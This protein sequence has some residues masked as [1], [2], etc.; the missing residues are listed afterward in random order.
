MPLSSLC[1]RLSDRAACLLLAISAF[2][3]VVVGIAIGEAQRL[4]PCPLCIFQRVLYLAIGGGALLA[5]AGR[6]LRPWGLFIA[7]VAALGGIAAA[8]YQ[9]WLQWMADP[10]LECGFGPPNLI[11]Q[12]VEW[13]G[14]QW[15]RLFLATGFCSSKEWELLGLSMANWSLLIYAGYAGLLTAVAK[16]SLR[17]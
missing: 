6:P 13:L 15:P 17:P 4:N 8:G 1:G 7:L 3:L 14:E 10:A 16:R 5:A 9:G 11:E 2:A 12:T